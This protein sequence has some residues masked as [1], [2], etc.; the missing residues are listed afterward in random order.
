MAR[1][2]VIAGGGIGGLT[3]A[4]AL[5]RRGIRTTLIEDSPVL[6]EV[7]A[8]IQVTPNAYAVLDSLGLGSVL[9]AYATVPEAVRLVAAE[10]GR[11]LAT[12][13]L[14]ATVRE[15]FGFPYFVVHR[16]DL[17][18][19]LASAAEA[20]TKIELR[21]GNPLI[22]AHIKDGGVFVETLHA[23]IEAAALIGADGIWSK[24]RTRV[25]RG[26]HAEYSGRIAFRATI[27]LEHAAD[28]MRRETGA[29]LGSNAHL[30]HYPIAGGRLLNLIAVAQTERSA[31]DSIAPTPG[32]EV[33]RRFADFAD[34]AASLIRAADVWTGWPLATVPATAWTEGP[35]ALLG[36]AAHAMVPFMA[37]GAAMAIEDAAVLAA[38]MATIPDAPAAFA[39]YAAERRH[40]VRAVARASRSTGQIYHLTGLS[41]I[42]RDTVLAATPPGRLLARLDWIYGWRPPA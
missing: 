20:E 37:Q 5:A 19:V 15:R 14:G 1:P 36:D 4:L 29:W 8:G 3:A 41:K 13:P 18:S 34:P 33:I 21:L 28:W 24:V 23:P 17:I 22:D 16:A 32:E 39:A 31:E 7:G 6:S 38:K 42:A 25:L 2:I 30:V 35:V 11:T 27:P 10:T 26:A 9:A 12:V 40:R